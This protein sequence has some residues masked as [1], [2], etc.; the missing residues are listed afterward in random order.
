[1]GYK[2]QIIEILNG[3]RCT[4]QELAN[5]LNIT[6]SDVRVYL[7]RIFKK[8]ESTLKVV[9][10]ENKYKIYTLNKETQENNNKLLFLLRNLYNLMENKMNF[11][12]TP[13][14]KDIELIKDIESVIE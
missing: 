6:E 7:N 1:M 10:T 2:E 3:N 12:E 9:G 13:N 11:A 14:S 8:N 5:I 4:T